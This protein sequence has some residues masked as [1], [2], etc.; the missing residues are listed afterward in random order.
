MAAV[1]ERAVMLQTRTST[2]TSFTTTIPDDNANAYHSYQLERVVWAAG[3]P[4]GIRAGTRTTTR[5]QTK[6][7]PALVR[8]FRIR[9]P[10]I[11][12]P[13]TTPTHTKAF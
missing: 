9:F 4:A 1:D 3:P 11:M 7:V 2:G 10:R 8:V 12:R 6:L 13:R 5:L